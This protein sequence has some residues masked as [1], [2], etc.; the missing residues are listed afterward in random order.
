MLNENIRAIR[1]SKGLSQEELAEKLHVVRQTISKWETGLSVPDAGLLIALSET[2]ETPVSILLG[3]TVAEAKTD[4]IK[5]IAEKL[6]MINAQL[7]KQRAAG[8]TALRWFFIL[9]FAATAATFAVLIALNS[10]YL[11]WDYS[12][13][14]T[15]V[16]GVALHAFEWLFMRLAPLIL[17]GA[18]AGICLTRKKA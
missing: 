6:E 18:V 1:K 4:D 2:L 12:D 7:A 13:A 15:A 14:E 10:P 9:L 3:E 16:A 8:R 17:A 5:A 11:D